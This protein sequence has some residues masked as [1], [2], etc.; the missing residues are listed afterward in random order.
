MRNIKIFFWVL[1]GLVVLFWAV[2]FASSNSL[3]SDEGM[4]LNAAWQMWQGKLM[5]VDFYEFVSPGAEYFTLFS[6][7]IFG[8]SYLSTKLLAVL[9]LF[10]S[11]LGVFYTSWVIT[12]KYSLS[13]I[14]VMFWFLA[15]CFH[16]LINHNAFSSF[17]AVWVLLLL[18]LV[19]ERK[20]KYLYFLLGAVLAVCFWFLQTKGLSLLFSV[21]IIILIFG[22]R[23]IISRVEALVLLL[24]GFV[25]LFKILFL[26]WSINVLYHSL[27]I[28]PLSN[29]YLST[30]PICP[31]YIV[32]VIFIILLMFSVSFY[33]RKINMWVLSIMQL[34][35]FM[36]SWQ[37]M[38]LAHLLINILP[39]LRKGDRA[40]IL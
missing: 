14:A 4:A 19:V 40:S 16:P 39:F 1:F 15:S 2:I 33:Q 35:L 26:P 34:G 32:V 9:F 5:F 12:K 25:V 28:L 36:S 11:L 10:F 8:V 7:K 29:N 21:S 23:K 20:S 22:P 30:T 31:L 24:A 18:F 37:L 17:V 6:W 38:D 13:L 27:I 3:N